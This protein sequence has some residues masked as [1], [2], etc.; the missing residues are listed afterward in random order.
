MDIFADVTRD[1]ESVCVRYELLSIAPVLRMVLKILVFA[2]LFGISHQGRKVDASIQ[3]II[4]RM[5]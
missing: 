1:R 5:A 4:A 2:L 3:K